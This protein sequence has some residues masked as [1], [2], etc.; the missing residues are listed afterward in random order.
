MYHKSRTASFALAKLR[1]RT[2]HIVCD[3]SV[4]ACTVM[5]TINTSSSIPAH[6][7][8]SAALHPAARPL[9]PSAVSKGTVRILSTKIRII[10][11]MGEGK[12]GF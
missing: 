12:Q 11:L 9:V 6:I 4:T 5:I 3:R 2:L 7:Y 10:E 1:G 8:M